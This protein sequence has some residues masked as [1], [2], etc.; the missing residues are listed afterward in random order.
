MGEFYK[1]HLLRPFRK[2]K[3]RTPQIAS[4]PS[5]P[6]FRLTKEEVSQ[7]VFMTPRNYHES[8]NQATIREDYRCIATRILDKTYARTLRMAGPMV[9]EYVEALECCHIF[10]ESIDTDIDGCENSKNRWTLLKRLGYDDVV[11][12]F[13]T[14]D[15]THSLENVMMVTRRV[16]DDIDT[17]DLWFEPIENVPNRY[18]MCSIWALPYGLQDGHEVTFQSAD[19]RLPLPNPH[20]LAIHA[21]CCRVSHLSGT[22]G[23]FAE[24]EKDLE[25]NP[26]PT[27]ESAGFARALSARLENLHLT[28]VKHH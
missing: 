23:L 25:A 10:A 27:I 6:S 1:N 8:R 22:S 13:A 16:H 19:P 7:M 18:R 14:S 11:S 21:T 3:G 5:E 24:L 9:G 26:D 20:Y 12:N 28:L 2:Y 15:K 17:L 4:H